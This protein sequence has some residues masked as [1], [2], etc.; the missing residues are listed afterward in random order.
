MCLTT[1]CFSFWN[2]NKCP[3]WATVRRQD[4][5]LWLSITGNVL[6]WRNYMCL[7][8]SQAEEWVWLEGT[9]LLG[10][11]ASVHGQ[12]WRAFWEVGLVNHVAS[13]LMS[14]LPHHGAG[15]CPLVSLLPSL[16]EQGR[17]GLCWH[18][19]HAKA[20]TGWGANEE[21]Q[22][23]ACSVHAR[24]RPTLVEDKQSDSLKKADV[25]WL[26]AKSPHPPPPLCLAAMFVCDL[27]LDR[28]SDH[29]GH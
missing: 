11:M 18:S 16:P 24:I 28:G 22:T 10:W 13:A 23:L 2:R 8:D 26:W 21:C 20:V 1:V 12:S 6:W 19:P 15:R 7:H 29:R 14:G 4:L 9:L 27:S 17:I 25:L 5:W 3:Y